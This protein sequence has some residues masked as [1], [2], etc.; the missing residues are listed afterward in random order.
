MDNRPVQKKILLVEDEKITA[1]I[2][3]NILENNNFSVVIARSGEEAIEAVNKHSDFDLV[4]MDIDLG[5]GLDGTAAAEHILKYNDLPLIFLSSHTEPEIV[6]K[7]EG[8]TSYGYILKNSGETVLIA[9]IKMAFRLYDSHIREK[10]LN[11]KLKLQSL[12]LDQID[13]KVTV[14][15]MDGTISYVNNAVTAKIKQKKQ[16]VIGTN[17]KALAEEI[18]I[19]PQ[20]SNII[21]STRRDGSWE[22]ELQTKS[23]DQGERT[24]YCRTKL[25]FDDEGNPFALCGLSTDIT[26]VKQMREKILKDREFY[27]LLLDS[28]YNPL[29]VT[30][31]DLEIIYSNQPFNEFLRS[32]GILKLAKGSHLN[33]ICNFLGDSTE[34]DY[35]DVFS[36]G[37]PKITEEVIVVNSKVKYLEIIKS[38]VFSNSLEVISVVTVFRDITLSKNAEKKYRDLFIHAPV[39]IVHVDSNGIITD[40][41]DNFVRII[42]SS[43][44]ALVGLETL[45]LPD[46]RVVKTI[47]KA[48][49]GHTA[50]FKGTY[51]SVTADKATVA[52]AKFTPFS[53]YGETNCGAI[54]IIEDIT[55]REEADSQIKSLL[56]EKDL[57]LKDSHHRVKNNM[58]II[59]GLLLLRAEELKDQNLKKILK[60]A[61]TKINSLIVLQDRLYKTE[62]HASINVDHYIRTLASEILNVLSH[63]KAVRCIIE[64]ENLELHPKKLLSTG[65]ILNELITNSLKHGFT[66]NPDPQISITVKNIDDELIL[67]YEDNGIGIPENLPFSDGMFGLNLVKLMTSELSGKLEILKSKVTIRFPV[68]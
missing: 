46:Q 47:K 68:L 61:A 23:G 36:L 28:S 5:K 34:S 49:E 43:K 7:T 19:N 63:D 62:N 9:A 52:K 53:P 32:L 25:I 60:E 59:K 65:I 10:E 55:E 1:L 17:I 64:S 37:K 20:F 54:G 11:R 2:E 44:Q 35:S 31:A 33:D 42:G 48:L 40:C 66:G 50:I 24:N 57:L 56:K 39:G 4:L 58:G 30:S 8:I 26:E 16:E 41:N 3:K 67:T 38:P 13:D 12:V 51:N 18:Y 22:G 15:G 14:T 21:E 27:E 29:F 45:K 6:K